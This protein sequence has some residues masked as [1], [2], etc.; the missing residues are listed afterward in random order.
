MKNENPFIVRKF[1]KCSW[2]ERHWFILIWNWGANN[3]TIQSKFEFNL[4]FKIDFKY[5][6]E[7]W[8][9]F[10]LNDWIKIQFNSNLT[11]GLRFNWIEFKFN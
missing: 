8:N 6:N 4:N 5:I 2:N 9:K 11:I 7:I 3:I 10:Q 1:S